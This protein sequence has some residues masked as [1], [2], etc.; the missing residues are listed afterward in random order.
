MVST[1]NIRKY[2]RT[3]ARITFKFKYALVFSWCLA[4]SNHTNISQ[5]TKW[6]PHKSDFLTNYNP[7]NL[8]FVYVYL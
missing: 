7:L 1:K 5:S 2:I 8:F 6:Y 3:G 4:L